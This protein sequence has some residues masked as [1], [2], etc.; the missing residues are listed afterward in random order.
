[1]ILIPMYHMGVWIDAKGASAYHKPGMNIT[2]GQPR[3]LVFCANLPSSPRPW[4]YVGTEVPMKV[5]YHA[6]GSSP[7][8]HDY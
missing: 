5:S 1:M 8:V 6:L 3:T 7:T 4:S 2:M